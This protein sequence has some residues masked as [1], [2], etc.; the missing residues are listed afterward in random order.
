MP[1]RVK[2]RVSHCFVRQGLVEILDVDERF[3]VI[4]DD[5]ED[6][7]VVLLDDVDGGATAVSRLFLLDRSAR[8]GTAVVGERGLRDLMALLQG[9]GAAALPATGKPP[10][11]G[12]ILN[13]R[14]MEV[15]RA[16]AHLG[17]GREVAGHLGTS[18]RTVARVRQRILV[19]LGA[20]NVA[21]AVAIGHEKGWLDGRLTAPRSESAR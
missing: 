11:T 7:D 5:S 20:R 1:I 12:E 6:C 8:R 10:E 4:A 18:A 14:E 16:L 21:H 13:Q 9:M 19:K 17:T 15:L 3:T 2:I